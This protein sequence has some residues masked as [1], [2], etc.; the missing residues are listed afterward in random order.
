MSK[1]K[2]SPLAAQDLDDIYEYIFTVL[3]N[4]LAAKNTVHKIISS[5]EKLSPNFDIG[6]S[7]Q[8]LIDFP[9]D[10]K[11]I[12]CNNYLV[13]YRIDS[14]NVY[15]IRILYSKSDYLSTLFNE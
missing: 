6:I 15:I 10:Y 5:Y 7:L 4:P 11:F 9:T 12:Q 2:L 3:Q 1:I 13:F 14:D 8:Q